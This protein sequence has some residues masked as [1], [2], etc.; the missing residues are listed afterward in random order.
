M[1]QKSYSRLYSRKHSTCSLCSP[2]LLHVLPVC[3]VVGNGIDIRRTV[4]CCKNLIAA[5]T[6]E[7]T[8]HVVRVH[9]SSCMCCR[10]VCLQLTASEEDPVRVCFDFRDVYVTFRQL[11]WN[12]R[13]YVPA[14]IRPGYTGKKVL[15]LVQ[16]RQQ[17]LSEYICRSIHQPCQLMNGVIP[18]QVAMSNIACSL[19]SLP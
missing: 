18:A 8:A 11:F 1:L 12:G 17:I 15:P 6:L 5:C 4:F 16:M 9:L 13:S 10:F 3:V 19:S 14:R 7:N 2:I